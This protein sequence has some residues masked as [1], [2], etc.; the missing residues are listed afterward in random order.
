MI[1]NSTTSG[2]DLTFQTG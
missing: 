2:G 1:Q